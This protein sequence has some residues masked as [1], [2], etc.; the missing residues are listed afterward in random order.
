MMSKKNMMGNRNWLILIVSLLIFL[1]LSLG[2]FSFNSVSGN[3]IKKIP[4]NLNKEIN[5][6]IKNINNSLTGVGNDLL[7]L[8]TLPDL[9]SLINSQNPNLKRQFKLDLQK[10][11]LNL[12]RQKKIYYEISYINEIGR[13]HV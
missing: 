6:D 10:D 9:N 11:F 7:F 5:V 8:S 4:K 1:V 13:A 2:N 12:S 3:V